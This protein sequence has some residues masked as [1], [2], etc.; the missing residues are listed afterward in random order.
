MGLLDSIFGKKT[1]AAPQQ[2]SPQQA[3]L[4]YLDGV[5]L[6]PEVYERHDLSTL[7]DQLRGVLTEPSLGE[8]DGNEIRE[9]E[10]VLYLYGPDAERLYA[11][12]ES[13]LRG[14][15]LC[16]NA[17]VLIRRGGPGTSSREVRL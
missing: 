16:R 14:Y 12:I 8:Y 15:P 13:T 6:P 1:S 2:A 5:S 10:T 11:S 3:V 7:E 17:R 4:V 9:S